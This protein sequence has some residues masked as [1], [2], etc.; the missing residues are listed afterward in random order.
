MTL[1][2]W[3]APLLGALAGGRPP[4]LLASYTTVVTDVL[5]L[6]LI[7]PAAIVGGVLIL[8]RSALGYRIA[9]ALLG[10]I[11]FLLPVIVLSTVFQVRA[12]VSFTAGEIVGP[13]AGFAVLGLF[14]IRVLAAL[15]SGIREGRE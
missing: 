6:G 5:D 13:I 9:F 7:A 3:L 11:L 14:A 10:I 1:A 15:L 12:G 4:K 8:R 2:V